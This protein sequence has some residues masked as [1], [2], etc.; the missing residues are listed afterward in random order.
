MIAFEFDET[1]SAANR[2][3]HGI[4]FVEAQALWAGERIVQLPSPSP[5]GEERFIVT[6]EIGA[7]LWTAVVVYRGETIRLISVRRARIAEVK[8]YGREADQR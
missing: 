4:D 2:L 8:S 3:K 5:S 6:G 7:K 1:K